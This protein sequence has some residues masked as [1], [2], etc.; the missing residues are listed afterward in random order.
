MPVALAEDAGLLAGKDGLTLL[1]DRPLNAETPPHLLDDA[2]TPTSRHFIRNNGLPPEDVDPAGWTLTIDGMVE[3]PLK[4]TIAD[5]KERF[6]VKTLALTI[7]C[8][9]NGRAAFD[10]PAKGNQWTLGAVACSNWTGV[11]LRDVLEAAGVQDGVVYTA[12][13]GADGHL[14]GNPEKLPISRGLP[15]AKAMTD[16]VLIAFEMNGEPLHPMNGAPLRLGGAG[17]AR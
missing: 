1:N 11:R 10:P 8:G 14:S 5:L 12:H 16:N 9:G 3:R 15:I 13:E 7:E 2:I 4:L 6:P 17:L